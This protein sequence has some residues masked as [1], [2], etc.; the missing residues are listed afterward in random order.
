VWFRVTVTGR[1]L[2][3]QTKTVSV[4]IANPYR[5]SA[6][7]NADIPE[8]GVPV[9]AALFGNHPIVGTPEHAGTVRLWDTSTSW[10]AIERSRGVYTW[11]ALD[12]A[13]DAAEAA[14]HDET[15]A[16]GGEPG[17]D[18][19]GYGNGIGAG[20]ACFGGIHGVSDGDHIVR[21]GQAVTGLAAGETVD[22]ALALG[23]AHEMA[24]ALLVAVQGAGAEVVAGGKGG[25][26]FFGAM[27]AAGLHEGH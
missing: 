5:P 6:P 16:K 8:S 17:T 4:R 25:A 27:G 10:N 7:D 20:I 9:T 11:A 14:G 22:D 3:P 21:I 15:V 26:E 13:V 19:T 2:V 24:D 12:R 18:F 1:G 23:A